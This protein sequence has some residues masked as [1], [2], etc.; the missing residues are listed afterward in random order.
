MQFAV[1]YQQPENGEMFSDIV[2]DYRISLSEVFFP[3]F[4]ASSGRAALGRERGYVDHSIRDILIGELCVIR[5]MGVKLDLLFNA[6][7]YGEWAVSSR[8]ENEIVSLLEYFMDQGVMPEIVT[9]TSTFV[10][11]VIK[12][13]FPGI[14]LR[15]SVNMRVSSTLAIEYLS[16]LFDSFYIC[17]DIQRDLNKVKEIK[18]YCDTAGKKLL[19]L[20]NSGC[21]RNCPAQ[22]FHDNLLAHSTLA[23]GIIRASEYET[24]LCSRLY[25]HKE[26]FEEIL[27]STWIRPEDLSDYD[28]LFP[29]VKLATRQHSHPRTV[30]EAYASR[31]FSSNLLDLLEP[32]FSRLFKPWIIDNRKFPAEWKN[33]AGSC[34]VNCRHCGKCSRV[35]KSVL[36][37][38]QGNEQYMQMAPID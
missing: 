28:D 29:V 16:E 27:R 35:L 1:G 12:R 20:V 38:T 4:D 5:G 24:L 6:N 22:T 7:C 15:A 26:N 37:N 34:A 25:G 30:I 21:L 2:R 19:M 33:M 10:A 36:V 8:F 9:T 23:D 32:G 13:H 3:W 18:A 31:S 14:E 17:R 11:Q